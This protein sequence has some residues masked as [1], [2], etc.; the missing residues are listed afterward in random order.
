MSLSPRL[1][2]MLLWGE[3]LAD[4]HL[5]C[6][7]SS[8]SS[9]LLSISALLRVSDPTISLQTLKICQLKCKAI[10]ISYVNFQLGPTQGGFFL[11]IK[12]I[13]VLPEQKNKPTLFC[14][15]DKSA[16]VF[17]SFLLSFYRNSL[18]IS[19][20]GCLFFL[21]TCGSSIYPVSTSQKLQALDNYFNFSA[22]QFCHLENE[23]RVVY[24]S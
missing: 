22:P 10:L 13:K 19:L 1:L 3:T 9:H 16:I 15:N 24:T 11:I 20:V 2:P 7:Y 4:L 5:P 18:P 21:Y 8:L 14:D 23:S 6:S 12:S 17:Y